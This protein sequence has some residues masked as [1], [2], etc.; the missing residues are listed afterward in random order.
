MRNEALSPTF[1]DRTKALDEMVSF[2]LEAAGGDGMM[3]RPNSAGETPRQLQSKKLV[4]WQMWE[5]DA[6]KRNS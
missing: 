5:S 6:V 4:M 2:L 1:V 3:D